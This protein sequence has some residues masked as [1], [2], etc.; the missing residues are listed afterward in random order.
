MKN[1]KYLKKKKKK[2]KKKTYRFFVYFNKENGDQTNL[3]TFLNKNRNKNNKKNSLFF[4]PM[5]T[6][7]TVIKHI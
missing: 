7:K 3:M 2:K 1:N 5:L 6:T 4:L